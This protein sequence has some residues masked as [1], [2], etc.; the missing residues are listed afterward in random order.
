[1]TKVDSCHPE[2]SYKCAKCYECIAQ[3]TDLAKALTAVTERNVVLTEREEAW[4]LLVEAKDE[5]LV[6]HRIQKP[7]SNRTWAKLEKAKAA[8]GITTGEP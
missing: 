8:L 3:R 2:H 7:P 4:N 5:L 6:A 1:V